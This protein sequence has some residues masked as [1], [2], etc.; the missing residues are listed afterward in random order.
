MNQPSTSDLPRFPEDTVEEQYEEESD[1]EDQAVKMQSLIK[2][3]Q[4]FLLTQIKKEEKGKQSTTFT[5]GDSP[6]ESTL[7]RRCRPKESP[8]S[9]TPV[10]RVTST[11]VTKERFQNFQRRVFLSTPAHQSP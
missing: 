10:P 4:D 8:I 2:Q 7:P 6:I 11:P 5:P 9:P 1:E 3:M